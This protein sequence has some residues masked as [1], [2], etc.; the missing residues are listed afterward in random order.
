LLFPCLCCLTFYFLYC[1]LEFVLFTFQSYFCFGL[2]I[3]L[4]CVPVLYPLSFYF[5]LFF[6]CHIIFAYI[7]EAQCDVLSH[8]LLGN[9]QLKVG[10]SVILNFYQFFMVS[11]KS[12]CLVHYCEL[13][14]PSLSIILVVVVRTT[15]DSYSLLYNVNLHVLYL[16]SCSV[17]I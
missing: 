7:Y 14:S 11:K 8:Y 17:L 9:F 15:Q 1:F 5:P 3:H 6:D 12:N 16:K 13:Y 2:A 10:I 4:K